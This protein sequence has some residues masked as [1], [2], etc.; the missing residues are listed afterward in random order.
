MW[1]KLL[2]AFLFIP[3]LLY[4]G[5]SGFAMPD[6][7]Q[8]KG[9]GPGEKKAFLR[10]LESGASSG[11]SRIRYVPV[12]SSMVPG[13]SRR[14]LFVGT[15]LVYEKLF[16]AGKDTNVRET[17]S[18]A[19]GRFVLGGHIYSWLRLFSGLTYT[20]MNRK[21]LDQKTQNVRHFQVPLLIEAPL[22]PLGTSHTNYL[23]IRGGASYHW[24]RG[25]EKDD[26]FNPVED[27]DIRFGVGYEWQI[28]NSR[29]R[30]NIV[31]EGYEARPVS[32]NRSEF[33]SFGVNFGL[34]LTI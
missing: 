10:F 17:A 19:G 5:L 32:E 20:Q 25:A 4:T 33:S 23:L 6:L 1:K 8:Q 16:S 28:Y 31:L 26:L 21:T 2:H 27:W 13:S 12:N 24:L 22:I 9:W 18:Q 15:S 14:P 7:K 11:R 30:Y 34:I 29:F 3:G